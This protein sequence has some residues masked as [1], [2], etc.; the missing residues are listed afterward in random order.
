MMGVSA[1]RAGFGI[2][3]RPD[4]RIDRIPGGACLQRVCCHQLLQAGQLHRARIERI[5]DAAPGAL[6]AGG[7]AQM[8]RMLDDGG[9][10]QSIEYFDQ[11]ITTATKCGIDLVTKGAQPLKGFCIHAVSMPKRAFLVYPS[12]PP[13]CCWLNGK[14]KYGNK[15]GDAKTHHG[16]QPTFQ[17]CH[18]KPG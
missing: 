18:G 9:G 13:L 2:A 4:T 17:G 1:L 11:G 15:R 5:V 14:L 10:E 7:E 6:E 12:S 16:K 3:A 8:D